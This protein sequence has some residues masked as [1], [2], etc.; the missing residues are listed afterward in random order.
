MFPLLISVAIVSAPAPFY[1]KQ[2]VHDAWPV[3]EW[4]MV[5]NNEDSIVSAFDTLRCIFYKDGSYYEFNKN[6]LYK[7]EYRGNWRFIGEA[8][9]EVRSVML[10]GGPPNRYRVEFGKDNN[11]LTWAGYRFY[12]VR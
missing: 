9:I 12:K 6:P 5:T 7:Y 11:A 1:K 8:T 10:N 3:G 2:P 4:A